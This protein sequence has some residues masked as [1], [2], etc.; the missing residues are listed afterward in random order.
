[1]SKKR[2]KSK[3]ASDSSKPIRVLEMLEKAREQ[4]AKNWGQDALSFEADGHYTWMSNFIDGFDFVLELGCGDGRSTLELARRNHKIISI[5]ENS[6]CLKL[7]S[8]QLDNN[9]FSSKVIYRGAQKGKMRSYDMVS[10]IREIVTSTLQSYC[11][12]NI[13]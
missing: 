12:L 2:K 10:Y 3:I 9:G 11:I 1:M 7:A 13:D 8:E 5:D 6:A 4:Y